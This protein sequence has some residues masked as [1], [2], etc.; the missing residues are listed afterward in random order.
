MQNVFLLPL[1]SEQDYRPQERLEPITHLID[2]LSSTEP[3][4]RNYSYKSIKTNPFEVGPVSNGSN[5]RELV[6][7]FVLCFALV[8][9]RQEI[10]QIAHF[11]DVVLEPCLAF[12]AGKQQRT[13]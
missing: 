2:A 3:R 4:Y 9:L 7:R 5:A 8:E 13:Q 6:D 10:L 1:R 12:S 11:F